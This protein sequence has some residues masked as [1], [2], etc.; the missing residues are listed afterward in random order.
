MACLGS[1]DIRVKLGS[2]AWQAGLE[3]REN[4]ASQVLQGS[5]VCEE[6]REIREKKVDWDFLD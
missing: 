2:G 1:L 5:Q 4:L 3:T 6:R